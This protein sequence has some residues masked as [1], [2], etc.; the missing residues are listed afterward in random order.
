MSSILWFFCSLVPLELVNNLLNN[1]SFFI[2]LLAFDSCCHDTSLY[3][4]YCGYCCWSNINPNLSLV[5]V[6]CSKSAS[7]R[8]LPLTSLW[9]VHPCAHSD[10]I[11]SET[12]KQVGLLRFVSHYESLIISY[13]LRFSHQVLLCEKAFRILFRP[14]RE[15]KRVSHT[16]KNRFIQSQTTA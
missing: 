14:I 11:S 13:I 7:F 10:I 16:W 2:R 3:P 15:A 6:K 8:R 12:F 9:F 4:Y 5:S 1:I